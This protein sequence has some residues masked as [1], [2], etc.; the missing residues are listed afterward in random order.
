M[1]KV[2]KV[3]K[4]SK[5]IVKPKTNEVGEPYIPNEVVAEDK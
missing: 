1:A 5:E 2:K 3:K 4:V